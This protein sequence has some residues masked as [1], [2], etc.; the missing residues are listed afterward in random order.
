MKYHENDISVRG[1]FRG[2]TPFSS[3]FSHCNCNFEKIPEMG[4]LP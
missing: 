1:F 2:F 3:I 4:L